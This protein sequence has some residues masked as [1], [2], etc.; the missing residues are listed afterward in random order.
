M[1]SKTIKNVNNIFLI[2]YPEMLLKIL[3]LDYDLSDS[4]RLGVNF[5]T[6]Y[7]RYILLYAMYL[8][9]F[10]L[11]LFIF[12]IKKGDFNI[13]SIVIGMVQFVVLQV[14]VSVTYGQIQ[15]SLIIF[16]TLFSLYLVLLI[17]KLNAK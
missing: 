2:I 8:L 14:F 5:Y 4:F 11:F 12:I 3:F 13:I 10:M 15:L 6:I 1:K 9:I 16:G 17:G 7:Y